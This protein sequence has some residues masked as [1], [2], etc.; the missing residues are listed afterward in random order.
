MAKENSA[1]VSQLTVA[2]LTELVRTIVRAEAG[3]ASE[4]RAHSN[5]M[6]FTCPE[7]RQRAARRTTGYETGA[8]H[9]QHMDFT[10]PD[11]RALGQTGG[12]STDVRLVTM[13]NNNLITTPNTDTKK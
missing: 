3:A 11:D 8:R 5:H 1:L 13:P 4:A 9:A 7:D 12:T 2:E 10:C 6:D